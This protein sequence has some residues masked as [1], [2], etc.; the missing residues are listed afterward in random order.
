[1]TFMK[2]FK[3]GCGIQTFVQAS[4]ARLNFKVNLYQRCLLKSMQKCIHRRQPSPASPPTDGLCASPHHKMVLNKSLLSTAS[5]R[6][7]VVP[8]WTTS[9]NRWRHQSSMKSQKKFNS[10]LNKSKIPSSSLSKPPLKI[11]VFLHR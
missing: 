8:T 9:H 1:M 3:N 10:N 4:T 11:Q 7:K 2:F 5:P 6:R